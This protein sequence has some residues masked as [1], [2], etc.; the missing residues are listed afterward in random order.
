MAEA[1]PGVG[2]KKLRRPFSHAWGLSSWV[3]DC[4]TPPRPETQLPAMPQSC[5]LML[6]HQLHMG[7]HRGRMADGV[8]AS[9]PGSRATSYLGESQPHWPPSAW[10]S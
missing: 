7:R 10:L 6:G 2:A 1:I 5:H 4:A 9:L 3:P 8:L